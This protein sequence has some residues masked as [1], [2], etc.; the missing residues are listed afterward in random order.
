[1]NA[2]KILDSEISS[3]KIASLPSRPTAPTSFGGKGYTASE[4]KA[5]FDRLPLFIIERFNTLIEDIGSVGQMSLAAEIPTGISE[6]HTLRELFLDIKSGAI[7]GYMKVLGENLED[8]L[9]GILDSLAALDNLSGE[10]GT[11]I[12][13]IR[14]SLLEFEN[15]LAAYRSAAEEV[16]VLEEKLCELLLLAGDNTFDNILIDCGTP[17]DLILGGEE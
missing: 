9:A 2:T 6:D 8:L 10:N 5:A 17:G 11:A 12:S 4:M 3:L 15:E 1:M 13:D 7:A 16:K 14:L